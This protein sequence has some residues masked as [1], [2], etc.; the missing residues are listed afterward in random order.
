MSVFVMPS[1]GADMDEGTLVEWLVKPGDAVTRGMPIA[2]VETQKGAIEIEVFETGTLQR[3]DAQIGQT[4]PVG[5]PLAF[6][7]TDA[8][9]Q[10]APKAVAETPP[11]PAQHP[12]VPSPKIQPLS[13][14]VTG[15]SQP[16]ASPAARKAATE[17][18]LSL[19]SVTGS[20]PGGAI[21]LA[22]VERALAKGEKPAAKPGL[23]MAEMRKAIAAAMVRSKRDIPHYY[24][25]SRMD[26]QPAADW[27]ATT[28]STRPPE[29]RLLMG[30]LVLRAMTLAA[31]KVPEM[32]GTFENKAFQPSTMVNAG[33]VVALRG[34][35]LIA[36]A[37]LDAASLSLD[38]L[39]AAMT[40]VV[41]RARTGRLRNAE[42]TNGTITLTSMGDTG[43]EALFG[44]I[45]PPQVAILGFGAPTIQ[46]WVVGTAVVPRLVATLTLAADHRVS[47]GRRGARFLTEVQHLLSHPE[48]L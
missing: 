4:L 6:I 28:N 31:A 37:I 25:S 10:P 13:P 40:D 38:G 12:P 43:A 19:D 16:A 11:A 8:V 30:T 36:P 48:A 42:L 45:Y 32:N 22:D 34:G 39:M 23:D 18:G 35:G 14:P 1:L 15:P 46:P 21:V 29:T 5:A 2:V 44:V 27:L 3:I 7:A 17:A 26:L 9:A 24:L 47:D 20:G 33:L 41:T